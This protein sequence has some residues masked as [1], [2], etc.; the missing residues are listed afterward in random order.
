MAFVTRCP[1]CGAVW[2]LPDLDTAERGPVRCSAC[3]NS[4]DATRELMRVRDELF[5]NLPRPAV[6]IPTP[7]APPKPA[8]KHLILNVNAATPVDADAGAIPSLA[9]AAAVRPAVLRPSAGAQPAAQPP[10]QKAPERKT[11][12]LAPESTHTAAAPAEAPHARTDTAPTNKP[13]EETA[14]GTAEPAAKPASETQPAAESAPRLPDAAAAAKRSVHAEPT[15]RLVPMAGKREPHLASTP[16]GES[17]DEEPKLKLLAAAVHH[18]KTPAD[19]GKIIPGEDIRKPVR[20]VMAP[21]ED[22]PE[23]KKNLNTAGIGSILLALVLIVVLCAVAGIIFNQRI[24]QSLPQTQGFFTELCGKIP[25]PG[26]YLADSKAFVVTKTSL[27]PL[28]ES[29]NYALDVTIVNGSNVAQAVPWL[30]L[31]LLDDD[32]NIL[33]TKRLSPQD[34]L[35]DPA[36]TPSI[37]PNRSMTVRVSLQTNVTSARCVVKPTYPDKN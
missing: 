3:R 28:D 8:A 31:D 23:R 32:D 13:V 29:G 11:E 36:A 1:Y 20:L 37:A 30:E 22:K 2:L 9:A 12:K 10:A 6:T 33:M 14:V 15:L 34:Y 4:F 17:A 26:F 27:R 35:N 16:A 5:P 21:A 25:C 7:F 18:E 19:A 24:I